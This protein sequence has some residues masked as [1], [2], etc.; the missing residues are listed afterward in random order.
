MTPSVPPVRRG[1]WWAI[2]LLIMAVI[3]KLSAGSDTP[4]PPLHHPVDWIIHF[5]AYLALAFA[6]GRA[7]GRWQVAWV[8]AAWFGAT[9]EVHQAFV[10]GREAGITDWLFDTAG[11]WLGARW[12]AGRTAKAAQPQTD[13]E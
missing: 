9:D 2:A 13:K 10:P 4:G 8:V 1:L 3:W 11:A 12:G 6:L 5:L 7:T